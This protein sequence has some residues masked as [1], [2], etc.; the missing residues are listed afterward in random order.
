MV[1]RVVCEEVTVAGLGL[2]GSAAVLASDWL[3]VVDHAAVPSLTG[4]LD[5]GE[6]AAFP[7]A[8]AL[9]AVLLVL[10]GE[11]TSEGR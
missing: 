2:T 3:R 1:P 5:A 4:R 10:A 6:A 8:L 11:G 7:L 9:G